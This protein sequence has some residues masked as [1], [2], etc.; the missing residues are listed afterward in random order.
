MSS[1]MY[2]ALS[3]YSS[4]WMMKDMFVN[5]RTQ[6]FTSSLDQLS[7]FDHYFT[8]HIFSAFQQQF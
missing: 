7:E 8:M 6:C 3:Y 2:D 1:S 5:L 4:D